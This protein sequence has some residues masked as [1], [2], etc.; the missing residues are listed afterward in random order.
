MDRQGPP[1]IWVL[2]GSKTGDN[3]QVLRVAEATGLPFEVRKIVLKPRYENAKPRVSP[4]LYQIDLK[5]SD[6]LQPP[7]PELV[8]AIGRRMSLVALWIKK[9]SSGKSR[10]VLFNAPKGK[11]S[12][13]DLTIVPTYYQLAE[14]PNVC[15]IDLPLIAI[16]PLRLSE[17]RSRFAAAFE[18]MPKPLHVLLLG[19]GTGEMSFDPR[20]AT[21]VLNKMRAGFASSGSIYI[22]TS[23]RT[24][25]KVAD[26][27][28]RQLKPFDRLYRWSPE[29][30]DN[31]YLGLLAH[32]DTFTVTGDSLSMLTEIARLGKPLV[33]AELPAQRSTGRSSGQRSSHDRMSCLNRFMRWVGLQQIRDFQYM[34]DFLCDGGH[35]VMLGDTP[36][37]PAV[38]PRDDTLHVAEIVRKLVLEN[39]TQST[40]QQSPNQ[41]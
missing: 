3:A 23:R 9:Q 29:A 15:R 1:R 4:S 16:D 7:W 8:I 28:D 40:L 21:A 37:Q 10:I 20:F 5:L 41:N 36:Q 24:P 39:H 26:A 11:A 19:G 33:I 12:G 22:S 31:P 6:V 25:A 14:T 27:M 13:F 35:A 30:T 18:S 32:G 2:T 17:A 38:L 34:F